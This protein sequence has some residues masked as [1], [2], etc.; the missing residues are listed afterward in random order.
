[1]I[2][3]TRFKEYWAHC[4]NDLK[5]INSY[6]VVPTE[7]ALGKK[8]NNLK[9]TDFPVLVAVIPS[10]NPKSMDSDSVLESNQCLV[11]ILGKR[12]VSDKTDDTLIS[13]MSITQSAMQQL[14][15]LMLAD[16]NDCDAEFHDV[17][18]RLN[19]MSLHQDP[20]YNYLGCDG[21]SLSFEFDTLGF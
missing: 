17:M 16:R 12:P 9:K 1:M 13:D 18:K 10:S 2:S 15:N 3:I 6:H 20:E 11:F 7:E 14:K 19:V 8:I 4:A 21:W 5:A